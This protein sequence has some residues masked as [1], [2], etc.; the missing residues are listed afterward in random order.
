[1]VFQQAFSE[2]V[3]FLIK[4]TVS[5]NGWFYIIVSIMSLCFCFFSNLIWSHVSIWILY[6]HHFQLPTPLMPP[7]PLKLM[8]SLI[9]VTYICIH[10]HIFIHTTCWVH[11]VLLVYISVKGWPVEL[12]IEG[13]SLENTD[14]PSPQSH[15]LPEPLHLGVS[16]SKICS[17]HT[18]LTTDVIV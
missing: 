2:I 1:M 6:L 13:L 9:I 17:I 3:A 10:I 14:C 11:V 8:T 7:P 16:P 5:P 18:G 12:C 15:Y 4:L